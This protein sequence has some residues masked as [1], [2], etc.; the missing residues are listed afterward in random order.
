MTDEKLQLTPHEAV[1]IV[2]ASPERLVVL[3]TYAP[4]GERPPSHR[5]PEQ[6]ERFEVLAGSLR[7]EIDGSVREYGEG[8]SFEVPR[9][10]AHRMANVG[11]VPARV[12]W[13]T[14]PAGH[15][16]EWFRALDATQRRVEGRPL[17]RLLAFGPLLFRFR[18][19][20]RLA[21]G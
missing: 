11:P 5:H 8:E 16:L 21:R 12:S 14:S 7:V 15:T 13:T 1:E 18:H 3:A 4:G 20:F 10:T 6:D 17:A 19:T 9:G 2:H